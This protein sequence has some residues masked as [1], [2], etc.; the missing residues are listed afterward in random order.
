[1]SRRHY[2]DAENFLV[3]AFSGP[4]DDAELMAHMESLIAD[5]RLRPGYR[6]LA[7]CRGI[8]TPIG[9]TGEGLRNVAR[10]ETASTLPKGGRLALV[11]DQDVTYGLGRMFSVFAEE[12]RSEIRVFSAL[13]EACAWLG[14]DPDLVLKHLD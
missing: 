12:N 14:V 1:M 9:I 3:C 4:V 11:M 13:P 6:E 10:R 5:E 8:S 2:L 7:D